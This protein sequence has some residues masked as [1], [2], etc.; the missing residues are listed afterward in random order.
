MCV[1]THM[2]VYVNY[3]ISFFVFF[4]LEFDFRHITYPFHVSLLLWFGL[5]L[6]FGTYSSV[7]SFC[8]T[9]CVSLC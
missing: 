6:S 3:F 9:F 4:L 1:Y 5:L 7:S 8:L 2:Y